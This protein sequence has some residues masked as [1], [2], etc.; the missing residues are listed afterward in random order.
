MGILAIVLFMV[1]MV[2]VLVALSVF[3]LKSVKQ[4]PIVYARQGKVEQTSSLPI[5]LN[6]VGMIPII[7]A[8]AFA[9]FPYLLAQLIIKMGTS[10]QFV[11]EIAKWVDINL[12][13]YSGGDNVGWVAIIIYF[14]LV[15]AF[16]FFYTLIQFNPDKIADTIQKK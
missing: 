11:L 5:P 9:T 6:P 12:N 16:T 10:N 1:V 7:F 4:I 13:I 14:V 8:L 15:I 2:V 3:L